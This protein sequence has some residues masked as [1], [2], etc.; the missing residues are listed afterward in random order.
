[1]PPQPRAHLRALRPATHG[2]VGL[3]ELAAHGL[4][5]GDVC[6]FSV[7][8]NPLGPAPGVAA[9]IHATNPSRYPDPN[10][11][12][13]RLAL[14][15][16]DG[17]PPETITVGNGATE[18]IWALAAAYLDPGDT[19]AIAAPTFG[20]YAAA[21][22][23]VAGRVVEWRASAADG[24]AFDLEA[25]IT[26]VTGS[27]AKLAY[28]GQPNNPTGALLPAAE[29][30]ALLTA[31]PETLFVVDESYLAFVTDPPDLRPLLARGNL[32]LLRSLTKEYALA[33]LRLGYASGPP[34]ASAALRVARPA[35]SV[36]AV[37][38]AAGLA[39]L[40][41][42]EHLAAARRVVR[43]ARDYLAR[44]L[45]ALGFRV[46]PPT[47]N[48]LLVEVGDGAALRAALLPRGLIVRECASFGLPAY[49]RIGVRTLPECRRLVA[50]LANPALAS[51]RPLGAAGVAR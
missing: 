18:L 31:A 50:A 15:R 10:S 7:S 39:A 8:V 46:A 1:M 40:A 29:L 37:A 36:N 25:F 43:E 48:F 35:W 23:A 45:R 47:A 6:D 44:E 24:F 30:A 42:G 51:L 22:A 5:P 41:D 32:V 38:Q 9:A 12:A 21:V 49:V 2:A 11:S 4:A 3:A 28:L 20:E 14:A 27:R 26:A 17:V 34:E 33:G 19:A 16:R 13:L